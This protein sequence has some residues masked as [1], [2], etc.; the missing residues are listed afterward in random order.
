MSEWP[1]ATS[2][3]AATVQMTTKVLKKSQIVQ[4]SDLNALP[5][6]QKG[7]EKL[8]TGCLVLFQIY[9]CK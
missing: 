9:L 6:A 1:G 4:C 8:V 7:L 2:G 3:D 5:S